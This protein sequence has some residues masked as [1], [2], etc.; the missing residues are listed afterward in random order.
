MIKSMT[1]YGGAKGSYEK[2]EISI[3]LRSVNSRYLDCNIKMPRVYTSFEDKIKGAVQNVITRGKVDV[4]ITI[5]S[6]KV[7]DIKISLNMPLAEAYKSV[8][9]EISEKF[10]VKNDIT[11]NVISRFPDV[12]VIQKEEVDEAKL[13]NEL[14]SILGAALGDFS[15]MRQIEGEKLFA[16]INLKLKNI[17]SIVKIV[18]TKS[19]ETVVEYRK[20]LMRK[21][22]EVLATTDID[23]NRILLEA[24]I[25]SD[26][27]A[28][29][30]EIVR[31]KSHI[32]QMKTLLSNAEPVGRKIDFLIQEMNREAN[33]IG[34][35]VNNTEL[36]HYVIDLKAEIEKI[37]EQAQNIE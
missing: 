7:D 8:L 2:F 35:K 17:E 12:L 26:R 32:S 19:P 34:S 30:E 9:D 27:V 3:E 14:I 16:D 28:V 36:S 24:A 23:Q 29:D 1:G 18:E 11:A 37:R 13:L 4:Y 22:E 33:T 31:L 6:S 20:K 21:M 5:D 25:F 15:D 10:N